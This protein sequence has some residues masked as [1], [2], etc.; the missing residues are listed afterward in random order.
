MIL[1]NKA[2]I[3]RFNYYK[4]EKME[5]KNRK[6]NNKSYYI[7]TILLCIVCVFLSSVITYDY[8]NRKE[9]EDFFNSTSIMDDKLSAGDT[10]DKNNLTS[11][12]SNKIISSAITQFRQYIDKNYIGEIDEKKLL[13]ETLKGYIAG[14]DDEYSEFMTKEEWEEYQAQA[15]GNYV[16]IGIYM[17]M[18]KKDNIIVLSTIKDTPASEAGIE[19]G[20]I[21]VEVDDKSVIGKTTSE[22]SNMVKGEEGTKVKIKVLRDEEYKEFE[23]E[24]KSIKVFHVENEMIENNIGYIKLYTFDEDCSVEF[25]E[26]YKKL[27]EQGANKIILDLRDNTGGL[28]NEALKI[29]DYMTNKDATLLITK[30]AKDSKKIEK[31]NNEKEIEE[32]VVVLVNEYSASA[33]EILTGALKDNNRAIIVGTKTYGKGVI[34]TV[35]FLK[36]GSALKL[37]VEE[38]FTPNETKINK[39]GIEPDEIVEDDDE[40]KD[41]D[42]QLQK[43]IELLK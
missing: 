31:A 26:A 42:E 10:T 4:G 32:D 1:K 41:I 3:G 39:V 12:E 24:R 34:Q 33:S 40:T 27:K 38:Y 25:F 11:D 22:V 8:C 16:G 5:E 13:N 15:L 21:I 2:A 35:N 18:D 9:E 30:D 20:D 14:L 28:V 7:L 43:A 6:N 36:D 37:T 17:G 29:A 19:A 23:I